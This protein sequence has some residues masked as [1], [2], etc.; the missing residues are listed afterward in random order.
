[1][2]KKV[3]TGGNTDPSRPPLPPGHNFSH[4]QLSYLS[5]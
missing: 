3:L 5:T 2:V 4:L 1:M